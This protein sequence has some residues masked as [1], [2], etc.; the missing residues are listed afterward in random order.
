VIADQTDKKQQERAA[1]ALKLW[2]DGLALRGSH[3]DLYLQSRG[4]N[5]PDDIDT[6]RYHPSLWHSDIKQHRPALIAA[7]RDRNGEFQALHRTYLEQDTPK[8][9]SITN[10]KKMLGS[11]RGGSVHFGTVGG[12]LA[13]AEGIETALSFYSTSK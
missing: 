8:K 13:L 4:I 10:N 12:T 2:Q 11:A 7:V 9:L 1:H 5:V 3:A 6:L